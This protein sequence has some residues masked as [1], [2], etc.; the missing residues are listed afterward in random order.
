MHKHRTFIYTILVF[1]WIRHVCL[2]SDHSVNG[3]T[4]PISINYETKTLIP[5][6]W[7]SA[8]SNLSAASRPRRALSLI[9]LL[10]LLPLLHMAAIGAASG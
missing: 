3:V 4:T 5:N 1:Y 6:F 7:F 2:Q 10:L 8:M 9:F